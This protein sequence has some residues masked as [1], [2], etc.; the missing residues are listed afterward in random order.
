MSVVSKS[1]ASGSG[2]LRAGSVLGKKGGTFG[3]GVHMTR[4]PEGGEPVYGS[5]AFAPYQPGNLP[6]RKAHRLQ[7]LQY[8]LQAC[9]DQKAPGRAA[10]ERRI[11]K[12]RSRFVPVPDRLAPCSAVRGPSTG[13]SQHVPSMSSA[14]ISYALNAAAG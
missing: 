9:G 2:A 10:R 7:I 6:R 5:E 4:K 14:S 11:R 3:H 8:L 1:W 13:G 12:Q